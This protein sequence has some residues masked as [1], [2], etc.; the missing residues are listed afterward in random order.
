MSGSAGAAPR[1][2]PPG[3]GDQAGTRHST[4]YRPPRR[5]RTAGG[6]RPQAQDHIPS[7]GAPSAPAHE[8]AAITEG[9]RFR[10]RREQTLTPTWPAA[11]P[12]PQRRRTCATL[13]AKVA[14]GDV[15]PIGDSGGRCNVIR[16]GSDCFP[17]GRVLPRE[18]EG[19]LARR[20]V[21]HGIDG[22]RRRRR[23][24]TP[25]PAAGC[26]RECLQEGR[27]LVPTR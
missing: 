20:G 27:R 18:T 15:T 17:D 26:G 10:S 6:C 16:V 7:D 25:P 8:G 9:R 2:G 14:A 24:E 3:A 23:N 5:A 12:R 1:S 11:R 22:L 13:D 21:A 19:S 4:P